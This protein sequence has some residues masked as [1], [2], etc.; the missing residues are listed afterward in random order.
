MP[1]SRIQTKRRP[2]ARKSKRET[3]GAEICAFK[4]IRL[5]TGLLCLGVLALIA[6]NVN[7]LIHEGHIA[8]YIP[9]AIF[10]GV[11]V[12]LSHPLLANQRLL[13]T[14]DKIRLIKFR[15]HHNLVFC[16]HLSELVLEQ[17]KVL[18]YRFDHDGNLFQISP[19][20]YYESDQL[21]RVF[22]ELL[23]RCKR[24]IPMVER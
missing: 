2:R 10:A 1:R 3:R 6:T 16:D 22:T 21:E 15:K 19:R 11:F 5:T 20:A 23:N 24:N 7:F 12:F 14:G 17:G 4:P 13:V 9:L 8:L 18:S